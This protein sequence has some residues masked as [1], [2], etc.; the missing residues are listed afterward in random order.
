M[1]ALS[2]VQIAMLTQQVHDSEQYA[3]EVQRLG[4][5][6][7]VKDNENNL[8]KVALNDMKTKLDEWEQR[9]A[10]RLQVSNDQ[11]II[12]LMEMRV[13]VEVAEE[14]GREIQRLQGSL[15]S[16]ERDAQS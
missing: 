2:Y 4:E 13:A 16:K 12:R 3:R 9:D 7:E 6:L 14:R 11:T 5:A 1:P 10:Q 8:L 15:E